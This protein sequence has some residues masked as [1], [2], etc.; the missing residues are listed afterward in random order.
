M[1]G[2]ST[3]QLH[4][5][6]EPGEERPL[7]VTDDSDAHQY[8]TPDDL[9]LEAEENKIK[10]EFLETLSTKLE[11]ISKED[12]KFESL[13]LCIYDGKTKNREMAEATGIEKNKINNLK[14]KLK[15]RLKFY[16]EQ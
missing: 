8:S 14:K 6:N 15:R 2:Y 5:E 9:M 7:A 11:E 3:E 1:T 12:E 10:T 13:I 4:W 16:R